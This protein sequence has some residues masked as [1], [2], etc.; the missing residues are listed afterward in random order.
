[1]VK[2]LVVAVLGI[3]GMIAGASTVLQQILVAN[4]RSTIGSVSWGVFISYVGGT[5]TMALLVLASR[6]KLIVPAP[7]GFGLSLAPWLAAHSAS[8]TS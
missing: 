3:L 1:M 2:L 7:I 5:L 6:E 8:S 4:L